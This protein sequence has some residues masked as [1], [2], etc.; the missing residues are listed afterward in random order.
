[1]K[2]CGNCAAPLGNRCSKCGFD[3]PA[4]FKFC[5][6]CGTPLHS[7]QS[8]PR[9]AQPDIR[10]GTDTAITD[11]L[12]GERKTVTALFADIK[13]SMDLMEELDPEEA[14]ALVDPALRLMIEAVHH[15][16]GYIVQS[17]GDGIFALFGA[18]VAHE[19]HVHRGLYAALRMQ[20]ELR[21]YSS[22][23]RESG[24][25][26]V[27]VRVGLNTGEVVVRSIRTDD[28]HTEYTPIGHSTSLAARMQTLAPTGSIAITEA[29]Q[30]LAA[31]YFDLKPLGPTRVKGV[32]EPVNVYEVL[33][34][35]PLRTRLQISVQRGLSKFV[36]RQHEIAQLRRAL[37]L[38]REGRG[39]I[40]A[41][42][43][44]A[45]VGKSRLFHEFKLMSRDNVFVLEALSFSH[46]RASPYLPVI[47][48]LKDYFR[49]SDQDDARARR[50]KITGKVL[51]LDR[52][53]EYTLPYLF[54]LL[55]AE[56]PDFW[57]DRLDRL[58]AHLREAQKGVS[59]L[60]EMDPAVRRRR[61]RE[62][63]KTLL[64][65]ESLNQPLLLIFED[66]HWVDTETQALLDL[67]ADSI[68]TARILMMVNY[69]PEYAHHWGSKTY[70]TQ[71]R[72]DPLGR[73]SAAEM[74]SE[75]LGEQTELRPVKDLIIA[76][77]DG[78][79]FFVEE[80]V[81]ALFDQGVLVRNGMVRLA[82]PLA[83][84]RIP[85]T[86]QGILAARIDR[87]EAAAKELL[88]TL[89]VIGKDFP[90][91][92]IRRVTDRSHDDLAAD[93]EKLQL[94]EFVYE[95]PAFPESDYTFKHALTQEV[96]YN[97]VL[98]ERRR[99]IHARAASALEDI[100]SDHLE[101]HFAE[102]ARH[103]EQ[104]GNARKAVDFLKLAAEQ[105]RSRS[106]YDDA[107]HSVN[108]AL[109]LLA[110]LPDSR[111]RA[112]EEI[113]LLGI[114]GPLLAVTQGFASRE[115]ADTLNRGIE[116]S[117]R[118]GEGPEMFTV[119]FGLW[120]FNHARNRLND[121][122]NLAEKLLNLSR[123]MNDPASQAA[124]HSA[125]GSACLWRGEFGSAR[126][127]LQ[128]AI[129]IYNQDLERYLPMPQ[130]AVVPSRAQLA[131][132]LWMMG[133]TDQS[134]ALVEEALELA[135]KLGRPFSIA[136]ALMYTIAI[137]HLRGDYSNIRP[138]AESLIEI[139]RESGFP[140]WSAVASMIL[141]RVLVGEGSHDAGIVRMRQAMT[142][143]LEAG[144]ELVYNFALTLLAESYLEA[145]DPQK[146]LAA[147][148]EAMSNIE[149][150][151]QRMHEAELWRLRGE[152]IALHGGSDDEV[153]GSLKHAM[154][155]ASGQE[156]RAWHLR[157]ATSAARF[158]LR[159]G[160]PAEGKQF[161]APILAL[162]DEG[163]ETADYKQGLALMAELE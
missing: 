73:E 136:F 131:W 56:V 50:E 139:A 137:S 120:N 43:A 101:D 41:A 102:L 130:A 146:G 9:S 129:A 95:K 70:Y 83:A 20:S 145:R 36:G 21:A 74:L 125:L 106:A 63:I 114:R 94:A 76:R 122:K 124:A 87:L 80:M 111:E 90:F 72:L 96:A 143:L 151:N 49:I 112:L 62:A 81:Q 144:G 158:M 53:L 99:E 71:L 133:C 39:Q 16:D 59:S 150:S 31:G 65:R 57:Q 107:M 40:V 44:E 48:L 26:P 160:R 38:A 10:V 119:M 109:R 2:F 24:N 22:R 141:G 35:G 135:Q 33:G 3:N 128:T 79:P 27:E 159:Q 4:H 34:L 149:K 11:A 51:A 61:T 30:K 25:P 103:Y 157:A 15:Y 13:G 104:S 17:T 64:L 88:Q 45:G 66:L 84:V 52:A 85:P 69:R 18:P 148:T 82:K 147:I 68:G 134:R 138:Q 46:G 75:L 123:L 8:S 7:A 77:T 67:L 5:G 23:L 54:S 89:S 153:E 127:N 116:L 113:T 118:V 98:I 105:A 115:L 93:L 108:D 132:G 42:V 117:K 97:S 37:E 140:Y 19:D 55:R 154:E 58:D 91:A 155:I 32:S 152:L 100:F 29:T 142:T 156:A 86:V 126:E 163:H 1:M 14:R 92:V 12:E 121:S 28:Q 161:L 6:Q 78:N 110:T 162:I 60:N 47:E